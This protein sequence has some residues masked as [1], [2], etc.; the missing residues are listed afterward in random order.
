MLRKKIKNNEDQEI[1]KKVNQ[2]LIVHNMPDQAKLTGANYVMNSPKSSGQIASS[3][4]FSSLNGG[5]H[6]FK[7]VGLFIIAGG[8]IVVSGLAYASY[9]FI[10]KPTANNESKALVSSPTKK[11]NP[12]VAS[13]TAPT[14][15]IPAVNV[16]QTLNIAT[17]T[18]SSLDLGTS[19]AS[20]TM[21]EELLG[22]ENKNLPPLVDTDIDG[23][24]DEEE[25]AL[26]LSATSTD[27]DGDGYSD[28]AEL[29]NNYN[30]AGSGSLK[31]NSQL[32]EYT[33]NKINYQI[34]YPKTWTFKALNDD[35]T[36]VFTASDNSLIQISVQDNLDKQSILG[37]YENSFFGTTVTYDKLKSTDNWDGIFGEDNLNFYLTDKKH[38]N[39]YV[40][41][42]IPAIDDRL[43]YPNI[44]KAMINSLKIN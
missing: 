38:R 32:A 43:V 18:P 36:V 9:Y 35:Y 17:I 31:A 12:A 10:I 11:E 41:S 3:N 21:S 13:S 5:K 34:L 14:S 40:I 37:W 16:E 22:L 33:N 25:A 4:N 8:L 15:T 1:V 23:L 42:Y 24:Y 20:T 27:S 29:N 30:P 7:M 28:L 26:G 39:I 44:F 2:D 6:N 19:T